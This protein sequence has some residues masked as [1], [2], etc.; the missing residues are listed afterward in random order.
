M[1]TDLIHYI[2]FRTDNSDR[3]GAVFINKGAT[4]DFDLDIVTIEFAGTGPG[5]LPQDTVSQ[6]S[7][8]FNGI[9]IPRDCKSEKESSCKYTCMYHL[10]GNFK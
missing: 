8:I 6:F 9:N 1:D 10:F 3:C 2:L 5:V 7:C 4:V